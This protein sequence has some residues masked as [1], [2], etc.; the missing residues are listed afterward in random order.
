MRF[1]VRIREFLTEI[2][3]TSDSA[4]TNNLAGSTALSPGGGLRYPS[5]SSYYNNVPTMLCIQCGETAVKQEIQLM[6]KNPRYAFRGQSRSPNM[7]PF[8][9]LGMVS[10]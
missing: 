9:M 5:A 6:L 10:Y 2:L 4:N 8:H 3:P 1:T 7:V